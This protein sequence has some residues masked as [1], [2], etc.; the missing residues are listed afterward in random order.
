MFALR[1]VQTRIHIFSVIILWAVLVDMSKRFA[2]LEVASPLRWAARMRNTLLTVSFLARFGEIDASNRPASTACRWFCFGVH[3]ARFMTSLFSLSKSRW[4]TCAVLC[5]GAP[6]NANATK[7]CILP[8][9]QPLAPSDNRTCRY[10]ARSDV[11]FR[12]LP[13]RN[14][15]AYR[16]FTSRSRLRTRPLSLTSYMP[17]YPMTGFQRSMWG[18][19]C[20]V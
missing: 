6:M 14:R 4:L 18:T 2:M 9:P 15:V 5:G 13:L 7:R 11:S 1:D 17:S 3:Q 16:F 20:S 19:P 12:I 10:P 8:V